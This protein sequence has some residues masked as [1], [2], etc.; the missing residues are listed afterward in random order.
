MKII[1]LLPKAKQQE[2]RYEEL[3]HS[4]AMA[5]VLVG[6]FLLFGLVMQ[7]GVR[8]YL[9]QEKSAIEKNIEDVK[10]TANKQENN[11]IKNK[12]KLVNAQMNDFQSLAATTPAWSKVL[13]AFSNQVPDGVKINQFTAELNTKKIIITGQSPTRE[14]VIALYNNI[15]QDT[16]DFHDIDY[17][18]ENV[19]RPT[20]VS[21]HF[22]FFIQ[23]KLLK[24]STDE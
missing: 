6:I 9:T 24:P 14:Q 23:D 8:L 22:T 17:P 1:N 13:I 10:R 20:D 5:S 4:V 3:F 12:V 15:S 2:L 11:D 19:A 7:L 21:F 18:L 16:K